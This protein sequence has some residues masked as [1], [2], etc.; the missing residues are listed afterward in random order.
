[1]LL[2]NDLIHSGNVVVKLVFCEVARH[3]EI[4][5]AVGRIGGGR[6]GLW[7][8][9][10]DL[11]SDGI[12]HVAGDLIIGKWRTNGVALRIKAGAE[13][14]VIRV[15]LIVSIDQFAEVSIQKLRCGHR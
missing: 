4:V 6:V 11:L 3:G 13:R 9:A 2:A 8:V 7:K 1:V 10:Q 5:L 14:V 12:D 15:G